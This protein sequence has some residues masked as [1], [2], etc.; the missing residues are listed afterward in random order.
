M[1]Y[2]VLFISIALILSGC[3]Q[4]HKHQKAPYNGSKVRIDVSLLKEGVPV[5]Y[6]FEDG[7]VRIPFFVLNVK[8]EIHS[9]FDACNEC[10][11]N[12]LGFRY[13][14]GTLICNACNVRYQIYNLKDGL[15]G[16][17]PVRLK[18]T[19]NGGIYEIDKESLLQGKK[20]F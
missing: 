20:Y 1:K 13:D 17:Y 9:Y 14:E 2:R 7:K 15:G 16:C 3:S 5:F 6:A 4:E 18:G 8:N 10:Y 11:R 19:L 12:K